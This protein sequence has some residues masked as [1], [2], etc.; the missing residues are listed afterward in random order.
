MQQFD[1]SEVPYL[2]LGC[3]FC[4]LLSLPQIKLPA[5]IYRG[6]ICSRHR[7]GW[8]WVVHFLIWRV[9]IA[10]FSISSMFFFFSGNQ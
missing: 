4:F 5:P 1:F 7:C 8:S 9:A 6:L 2:A 3:L 10:V